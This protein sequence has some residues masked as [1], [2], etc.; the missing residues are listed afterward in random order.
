MGSTSS[1][2][3]KTLKPYDMASELGMDEELV[4]IPH[5]ATRIGI[6]HIPFVDGYIRFLL[7]FII[8]L[9]RMPWSW[10]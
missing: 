4:K 3:E 6:K 2:S 8:L 5:M 7:K 9:Y 1:A 10:W